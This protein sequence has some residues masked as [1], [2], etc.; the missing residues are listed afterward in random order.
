MNDDLNGFKDLDS[1]CYRRVAGMRIKEILDQLHKENEIPRKVIEICYLEWKTLF[2][3]TR[4]ATKEMF[5]D[6]L[7]EMIPGI[8]T[9]HEAV[10]SLQK[11][12][13]ANFN[14]YHN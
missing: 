4:S 2:F 6:M 13:M 10:I 11:H 1:N 5:Y 8:D 12:A 7:A 3:R 9:E 14:N